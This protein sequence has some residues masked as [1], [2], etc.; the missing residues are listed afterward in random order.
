MENHHRLLAAVAHAIHRRF[1]ALLLLAYAAAALWPAPGLWLR[2]LNCGKIVLFGESVKLS[3]PVGLLAF[4]L[5]SA[6]L[7]VQARQL[8]GLMRRPLVLCAGLI[9]NLAVPAAFM[10]VLAQAL[11]FWPN[12]DE[13]QQLLVGIG[14]VAA[15]PVAGSS[16]AWSQKH[17]GDTALSLGLVVASTL[18]SPVTTPLALHVVGMMVTG[19]Y[20]AMLHRLADHGAGAFLFV[21]VAVPS[22]AGILGHWGIGEERLKSLRPHLGLANSLVLLTL[23]YANAAVSLPSVFAD[24]DWAFLGMM[25]AVVV[26]LCVLAFAAGWGLAKVLRGDRGR[27]TALMFGLGMSNNGTGLV[28]AATALAAHPQVMLPIIFYNLAQHLV[29]GAAVKVTNRLDK[30]KRGAKV[31]EAQVVLAMPDRQQR[32]SA[33]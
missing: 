3:L 7:T 33:A 29:A 13:V 10:L 9:A 16:A 20:A 26:A 15:M 6:G 18:L 27:R 5:F 4:L 24:A 32:R 1:L 23:V 2:N 22:F 17:E 8:R 21:C 30:D 25:L 14:L 11:H 12:A 19:D 28:L 31:A